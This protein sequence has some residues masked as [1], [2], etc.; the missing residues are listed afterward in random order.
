[1]IARRALFSTAVLGD[2]HS[3]VGHKR[4]LL[5]IVFSV[6][7]IISFSNEWYLKAGKAP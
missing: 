4:H 7:Y 2:L 3:S 1:M 5:G 6:P